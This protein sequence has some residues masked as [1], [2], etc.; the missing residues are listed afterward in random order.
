MPF[1]EFV[2][3][4]YYQEDHM[5]KRAIEI[6]IAKHEDHYKGFTAHQLTSK[7]DGKL[8]YLYYD[9]KNML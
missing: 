9:D 6:C 5:S 3:Q 8:S 7:M 1:D 4:P 2:A